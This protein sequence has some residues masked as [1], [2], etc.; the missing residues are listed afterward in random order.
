MTRRDHSTSDVP[1]DPL[2]EAPRGVVDVREVTFRW[3]P[4]EG[5][6]EYRLEVAEDASFETVVVDEPVQGGEHVLR[7]RFAPEGDTYFWRVLAHD[8]RGWSRGERV[9]SF[10]AGTT[11]QVEEVRATHGGTEHPDETERF[12]P[13]GALMQGAGSEASAEATGHEVIPRTEAERR[14]GVAREGVEAGQIL[15]LAGAVAVAI[16]L[17]VVLVFFWIGSVS[18]FTRDTVAA[19]ATYVELEEAERNAAR[20]LGS[21]GVVDE[22]QGIYRIPI[23]RAMSRMVNQAY[24]QTGRTSA[25]ALPLPAEELPA[26]EQP[27]EGLSA[28]VQ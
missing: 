21:Y 5:I 27:A 6:D 4:V 7:E 17:I 25:A 15:G 9:E 10:I 24:Q 14:E 1:V 22:A 2:P 23:D 11:R 3:E 13:P 20:L 19:G 12:G 8:G 16:V 28:P 26:E 18:R